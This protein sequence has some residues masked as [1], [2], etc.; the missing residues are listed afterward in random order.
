LLYPDSENWEYI[1][2]SPNSSAARRAFNC[3]KEIA[4]MEFKSLKGCIAEDNKMPYMRFSDDAQELF[5][6][7]LH[8]LQEKLCNTENSPIIREHFGKYRSLMPSLA[9][10]FHLVDIADGMSSGP[11]SLS[12]AQMAAAWC[13]YL[14]SHARRIYGMAEDITARAA[15]ILA[16][17]IQAGKL[18]NNFT[19]REVQRKGWELLTEKEVV[20][21]AIQDLVEANWLREIKLPKITKGGPIKVEYEI[22]PK[23]T[24]DGTA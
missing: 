19:A 23:I 22:N 3:F 2:K 17:R 18:E 1:D 8:E 4:N 10:Q 7:W 9:L 6:A 24:S 5:I 15:G 20:N 12:A 14:E 21:G 16:D 11:V 13:E